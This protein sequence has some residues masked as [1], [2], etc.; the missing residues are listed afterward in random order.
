MF[1]NLDVDNSNTISQTELKNLISDINFGK[2]PMCKDEVVVK[3]MEDLD[4]DGDN[5]INVEE[6]TKG[7]TRW[8]SSNAIDEYQV[9]HCH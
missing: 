9:R 4:I 3:I 2:V 1:E 7:L 8:I 5:E 6:F